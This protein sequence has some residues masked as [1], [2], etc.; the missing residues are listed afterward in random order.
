MNLNEAVSAHTNWK[1]KLKAYIAKPDRSL[2]P[3]VVSDDKVCDLG[4][5][6]IGEGRKHSSLPEFSKLVTDHGR[7][8]KAAGDVIRKADS[9]QSV[10]EEVAL[11]ANSEYASASTGVVQAL[12]ALSGKINK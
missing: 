4:K 9:G 7:F 2:N 5:W 11:G 8:H 10:A 1:M 3:A 6:L 12:M